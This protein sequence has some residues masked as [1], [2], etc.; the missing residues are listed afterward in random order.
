MRRKKVIVM[1]AVALCALWL[2]AAAVNLVGVNELPPVAA[3]EKVLSFW[4][5]IE[6]EASPAPGRL[7][8]ERLTYST[9]EF[10]FAPMALDKKQSS[11][12]E[13]AEDLSNIENISSFGNL[14]EAQKEK[15]KENGFVASPSYKKQLFY[16]YEENEY[17]AVPSFITSDS[18]LQLWHVY[19]DYLIRT[20]EER[21]LYPELLEMS[22][23]LCYQAKEL[24]LSPPATGSQEVQ[25]ALMAYA[26][27]GYRILEPDL[28]A[29]ELAKDGLPADVIDLAEAE[30]DRIYQAEGKAYSQIAER[31]LDYSLFEPEGHYIKS[32][33]L[34][35]YSRGSLWYSSVFFFLEDGDGY[36]DLAGSRK[37]MTLALMLAASKSVDLWEGVY[38][39]SSFFFG[40]DEG[41][42]CIDVC[43]TLAETYE[44][45]AM[46]EILRQL[47]EP[48]V[49]QKISL[50]LSSMAKS[51]WQSPALALLPSP[52]TPDGHIMKSLTDYK[53]RPVPSGL[54]VPAALGSLRAWDIL[55]SNPMELWAD[56]ADTFAQVSKTI[57]QKADE[58]WR[59]DLRSG[60][61]WA[62]APLLEEGVS[63][64]DQFYMKSDAWVDK[65]L[66]GF[67]S[68]WAQ[69]LKDATIKSKPPAAE[70]GGWPEISYPGYV[71][72]SIGVY[73]RLSWLVR[74]TRE[75]LAERGLL[76]SSLKL[77]SAE[78]EDLLDFLIQCSIKE[79]S[80]EPLTEDD[81]M[82]I[83]KYGGVLERLCAT[84]ASDDTAISWYQI[85]PEASRSVAMTSLGF[86]TEGTY[87]YE[88]LG[89]ASELY[90]VVEIDG[91]LIMTRGAI[92]DFYEFESSSPVKDE[93]WQ[94]A[95]EFTKEL[96]QEDVYFDGSF[97]KRPAWKDSYMEAAGEP[98]PA[99]D[100]QGLE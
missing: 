33:E 54:D 67:L 69:M 49:T 95:L 90:V 12:I 86:Q 88:A 22:K 51:K 6:V 36:V 19:S 17:K 40:K 10:G 58:E 9:P 47:Y 66:N 23:K 59:A 25:K 16:I 42:S 98:L 76:D 3:V 82:S 56:Y 20:T 99:I 31:E 87:L 78:V 61:L 70:M 68:S 35:K 27:V 100:Y 13:I 28:E 91:R 11:T 92:F 21:R 79:L 15:I 80:G 64:E 1:L 71:E 97:K 81:Q 96:E 14:T 62:L 5:D 44:G 2:S 24:Y 41:L 7:P 45:Y 8:L 77:K 18:I 75:N 38:S 93:D 89:F 60:W 26:L 34:E 72:P 73:E 32:D 84:I 52:K 55:K 30:T 57:S 50:A 53:E 74:F 85:E 4:T 46:E 43:N 94:L 63:E 37:A 48:G 65:Q 29:V 39:I 83:V